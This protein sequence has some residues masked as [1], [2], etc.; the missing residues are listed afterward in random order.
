MARGFDLIRDLHKDARGVR[1]GTF[2]MEAFNA[3][4]EDEKQ[5]VWDR[6]CDELE[7]RQLETERREANALEQFESRLKGMMKD[8]DID[9]P[10]ALRWDME[11]FDVKV[12]TALED[13]GTAKQEIEFYLWKQDLPFEEFPRFLAMAC[14]AYQLNDYA[15]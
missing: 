12:Q 7:A 3:M 5:T 15:A 9:M 4:S 2:F 1:P 6:L 11:S 14:E 8:Y 10:T 13:H